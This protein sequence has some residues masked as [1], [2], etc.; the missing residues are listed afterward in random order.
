[1]RR[2]DIR[3][4]IAPDE[5]ATYKYPQEKKKRV[6]VFGSR[7]RELLVGKGENS[8]LTKISHPRLCRAL[9]STAV[10]TVRRSSR[11]ARSQCGRSMSCLHL[12]QPKS[13]ILRGIRRLHGNISGDSSRS[14]RRR[15]RRRSC[16]RPPL[17]PRSPAD[18]GLLRI[19]HRQTL[20]RLASDP[21]RL[22][23]CYHCRKVG[24]ANG[25]GRK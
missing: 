4:A 12:S 10:C 7:V 13:P 23:F 8:I 11:Q 6:F 17:E 25:G 19:L 20:G 21:R 16:Q 22:P 3:C 14:R 18:E 15:R 2:R 1:M 9:E 24:R 5:R